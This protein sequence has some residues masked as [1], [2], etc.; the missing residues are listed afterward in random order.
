[1]VV[2]VVVMEWEE[3][4]GWRITAAPIACLVPPYPHLLFVQSQHPEGKI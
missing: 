3:I 1:V 2:A 4:G